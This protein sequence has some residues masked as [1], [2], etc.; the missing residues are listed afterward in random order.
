MKPARVSN[1]ELLRIISMLMIIAHHYVYYGIQQNYQKDTANLIYQSGSFFNRLWARLLLPGGVVGGGI[2]FIIAGYFGIEQNKISISKIVQPVIFYGWFGCFVYIIL[3]LHNGYE[4][5]FDVIIKSLFPLGGSLYWFATVYLILMLIKPYLNELMK[6][7]SK[8]GLIILILLLLTEYSAFRFINGHYLGLIEG[9]LYY[10]IGAYI[11]I[12]INSLKKI[13]CLFYFIGF[14]IS[15]FLYVLIEHFV[16]GCGVIIS[17]VVFGIFCSVSLV[18]TFLTMKPFYNSYVNK[19]SSHSLGV[20]LFHEHTLFR[21][22]LWSNL[23]MVESFQ[24]KSNF[25]ILLSVFC[26]LSIYIVDFA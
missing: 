6:S 14:L 19:I 23:L 5:T 25:F 7:L 8:Y 24:W 21:K 17:T 18:L 10:L 16:F 12:K 20:Y 1:I 13:S 3:S 15:W 11:K 26:V 9:I 4:I 2:F 22:L